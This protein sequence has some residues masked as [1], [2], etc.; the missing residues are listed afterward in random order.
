MESSILDDKTCCRRHLKYPSNSCWSRFN[1][2]G[3]RRCLENNKDN[4][5]IVFFIRGY[6]DFAFTAE[7][8]LHVQGM[9]CFCFPVSQQHFISGPSLCSAIIRSRTLQFKQ[10][11][12][13]NC[14]NW[15][16]FALLLAYFCN[17]SRNAKGWERVF[18]LCVCLC[19]CF[20]CTHCQITI[21]IQL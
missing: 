7:F 14:R 15:L 21:G 20:Y 16:L 4:K 19:V 11:Y 18:S 3:D 9:F 8:S 5:V 17:H 12:A 13:I 6:F 2:K 1:W 10:R